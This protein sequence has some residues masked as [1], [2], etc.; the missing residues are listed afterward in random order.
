MGAVVWFDPLT[1]ES[2]DGNAGF[3]FTI[4]IPVFVL[5]NNLLSSG[6]PTLGPTDKTEGMEKVEAIE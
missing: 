3:R 1:Y 6:F 4:L 5:I 2:S